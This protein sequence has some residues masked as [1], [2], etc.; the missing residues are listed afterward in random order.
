MPRY[1]GVLNVTFEKQ[2]KRKPTVKTAGAAELNS[3]KATAGGQ[4]GATPII[5]DTNGIRP[6]V[7]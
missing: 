1:I 4:N 5:G 3:A 7:I 6:R 2:L